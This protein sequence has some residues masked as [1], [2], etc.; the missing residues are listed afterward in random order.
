MHSPARRSRTD[1]GMLTPHPRW[2]TRLPRLES[3]RVAKLDRSRSRLSLP[4]LDEHEIETHGSLDST[5]IDRFGVTSL[6]KG[7][8]FVVDRLGSATLLRDAPKSQYSLLLNLSL[9][10]SSSVSSSSHNG[11]GA[12]QGSAASY[13]GDLSPLHGIRPR[14]REDILGESRVPEGANWARTSFGF[15]LDLPCTC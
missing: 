2:S 4:T 12:S 6:V 9:Q 3:N 8:V 1:G 13:R 14:Y 10:T 7:C 15:P 11:R 5:T